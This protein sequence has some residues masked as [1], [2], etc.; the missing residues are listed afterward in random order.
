WIK[1]GTGGRYVWLWFAF[2]GGVLGLSIFINLRRS[3][4]ANTLAYFVLGYVLLVA[5]E[6]G[7]PQ[8]QMR[9]LLPLV[10][11]LGLQVASV[12]NDG[13]FDKR[14]LV[15]VL[16]VI[17]AVQQFSGKEPWRNVWPLNES[18]PVEAFVSGGNPLRAVVAGIEAIASDEW[19][20][21]GSNYEQWN[22][23]AARH[24]ARL[25]RDDVSIA[26]TDVGA[27]AYYSKLPVLDVQGLNHKA[28][29]HLPKPPGFAN[30]WGVE[31]WEVV[32]DADIDVIILGYLQYSRIKL[33]DE[34]IRTLTEEEWVR[35]STRRLEYPF[36]RIAE[37]YICASVPDRDNGGRYLNFMISRKRIDQVWRSRPSALSIAECW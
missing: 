14:V 16:A 5:L 6:G 19:P 10:P 34:R 4:F 7:D 1:L 37:K 9:F 21:R 15:A 36:D 8:Q 13:A 11:L 33:T 12:W 35:L 29:A 26:A 31:H 20:L 27:L 3:L 17:Y 18:T 30:A 23:P 32:F 22:A 2:Y 25:L 28:I 24:L